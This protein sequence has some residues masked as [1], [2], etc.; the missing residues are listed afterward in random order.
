MMHRNYQDMFPFRKSYEGGAK[1]IIFRQVERLLDKLISR[2]AQF[3]FIVLVGGN[4]KHDAFGFRYWKNPGSF[5]ELYYEGTLGR[6]LGFLQCVI[7]ASFTIA[8]P[9]YVSMAA[10]EAPRDGMILAEKM[11]LSDVLSMEESK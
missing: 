11:S 9:D 6:F 8:G 2:C 5:T 1:H 4:P 10:G 7:Q 3:M